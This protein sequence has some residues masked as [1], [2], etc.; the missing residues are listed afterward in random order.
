MRRLAQQDAYLRI[1][2]TTI[3]IGVRKDDVRYA[4]DIDYLFAR[5]PRKSIDAYRRQQRPR[6]PPQQPAASDRLLQGYEGHR[7]YH[8]GDGQPGEQQTG[9]LQASPAGRQDLVDRP[10]P[11]VEH[12]R[13][14]AD[15]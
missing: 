9:A 6:P 7:R 13:D 15:R 10:V 2:G 12:V 5:H 14:P 11:E 4:K 1:E 3:Y 8:T